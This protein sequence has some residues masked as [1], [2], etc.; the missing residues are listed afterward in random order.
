MG[1]ELSPLS[2]TQPNDGD[3]TIAE[4]IIHEQVPQGIVDDAEL[5]MIGGGLVPELTC[6]INEVAWISDH[7]RPRVIY[8]LWM[9]I[10]SGTAMLVEMFPRIGC[11]ELLRH[12]ERFL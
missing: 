11:P 2:S 3:H 9:V 7:R 1:E 12:S 8:L 4:L 6:K 5:V 10:L